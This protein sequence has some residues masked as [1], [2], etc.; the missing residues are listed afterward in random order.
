MQAGM[1]INKWGP[2]F[3]QR[4]GGSLVPDDYFTFD[5]ETSG[6][7][8]TRDVILEWGHCL[9]R[10][11]KVVDRSSFLVNWYDHPVVP[12]NYITS[13][14]ERI[15][16]AM[17]VN[18]RSWRIT[19][20]L[21]KTQGIPPHKFIPW[22]FEYLTTV[23]NEGYLFVSHNGV[24]FDS[25]R[26][27]SHFEQDLG[28]QFDFGEDQ[29]FDTGAIEKASQMLDVEKS[30]PRPGETLRA[31]FSRIAYCK[32]P[33]VFWNIEDCVKKYQL[34]DKYKL[35]PSRLHS[36][37]EDAF[38]LHCLM[39]EF[40]HLSEAAENS[41]QAEGLDP[42]AF[43]QEYLHEPIITQKPVGA[44]AKAPMPWE[45]AVPIAPK[46]AS[47]RTHA[48]TSAYNAAPTRRTNFRGQ[49]RR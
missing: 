26:V 49:K 30:L 25:K 7:H 11:R 45:P 35:D 1:I 17:R 42:A 47:A 4:Y 6:F 14:L 40:R 44:R 23:K 8:Q 32:A 13:Q 5:L 39:E 48:P 18:N 9:V 19:P 24:N 27:Q 2:V 12:P 37:G 31:Y 41:K 28:K 33:G 16:Q 29:V 46:A 43:R 38:A 34:V 15:A 20:E 21:L 10:D 36:A 3:R 22:L